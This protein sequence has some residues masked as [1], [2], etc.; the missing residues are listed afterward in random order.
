MI[1]GSSQPSSVAL[2]F[3]FFHR[4]TSGLRPGWRPGSGSQIKQVTLSPPHLIM[5]DSVTAPPSFVD[6]PVSEINS[7]SNSYYQELKMLEMAINHFVQDEC[8][9]TKYCNRNQFS[10]SIFWYLNI[11][12]KSIHLTWISKVGFT[13]LIWCIK[14]PAITIK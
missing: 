4:L 3:N 5:S 13:Y 12:T 14:G 10:S 11:F 2:S 7:I 6:V 1:K 9:L 8:A